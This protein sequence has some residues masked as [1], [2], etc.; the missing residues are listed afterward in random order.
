MALIN[1]TQHLCMTGAFRDEQ[2]YSCE[3][4][5][6]SGGASKSANVARDRLLGQ[7]WF[8]ASCQAQSTSVL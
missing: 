6:V 8:F 4:S 2:Q 3:C 5:L 7:R 1:V